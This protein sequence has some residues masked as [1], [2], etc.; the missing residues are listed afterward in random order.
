MQYDAWGRIKKLI[1]ND[2]DQPLRLQGQYFD[3]ETGLYYNRFRYYEPHIGSFISQDPLG[4]A[5]GEN[6]YRF[7][8]N[9]QVWIDPLGLCIKEYDIKKYGEFKNHPGDSL[10]GHEL[11]QNA[12][13]EANG[14]GPRGGKWSN[15]NPAIALKENPMHKTIS[16]AQRSLKLNT[17][18]LSNVSWR[19]NVLDNISIMKNAG[20]PRAKIAELA[21]EVKIFAKT[22]LNLPLKEV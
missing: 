3:R 19:K 6:V 2:V 20:V 17:K 18:N 11:L 13:L 8:P 22:V 5:A 4:L 9:A 16:S 1:I 12:W 14:F 10:T 15:Q 7:G 21:K